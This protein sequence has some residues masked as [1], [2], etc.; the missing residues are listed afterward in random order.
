MKI[1]RNKY[2]PFGRFKAVNIFGIV[3]VKNDT[4]LSSSL[5]NHEAIHTAQMKE[6]L[7][8]FFYILWALNWLFNIIYYWFDFKKAYRMIVFEQEA[9]EYQSYTLH[10][11]YR[12]LFFWL[13][14]IF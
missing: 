11:E 3:F 4:N 8:I 9:F 5:I 14:Y 1:I 7:F 12:S 10:I 13:K 6:L 2:I